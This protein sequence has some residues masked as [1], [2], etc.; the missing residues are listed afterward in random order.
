VTPF[1]DVSP[2]EA[3]RIFT[4]EIDAWWRREPRFRAGGR[5]GVLSF[6][7]ADGGRRL[8][9]TGAACTFV[10]G[11][12][13]DWEPGER[14]RFEWRA[15]AFQGD[16]RTEVEVLF[17]PARGGTRVVLEHRGWEAIRP[18]HPARHGL[19]GGAFTAMI[20]LY[21]GELATA[22]RSRAHR[23]STGTTPG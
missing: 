23:Q 21:W 19:E 5:D 20:G 16:E 9:E 22:F 8:V 14:L 6:E 17:A 13:L 10:V 18:D 11:R 15:R 3:F 7:A 2:D 12:V 4:E 1:V